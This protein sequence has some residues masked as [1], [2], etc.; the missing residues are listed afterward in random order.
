PEPANVAE[1]G[2]S[3]RPRMTC[4]TRTPALSTRREASPAR[5]SALE[6]RPM[7]RATRTARERSGFLRVVNRDRHRTRGND[8]GDGVLVHHLRHRVLEENHVLVER[9]D[10]PL[11]LDPVHEVDRDGDMLLAQSI[12]ERVLKQ[13]PFVAH[14]SAPFFSTGFPVYAGPFDAIIATTRKDTGPKGPV[15]DFARPMA[16]NCLYP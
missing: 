6:L 8:R 9:F 5:S 11:E 10:L 4:A 15:P 3:R 1:S 16:E 2:R 12:E 14:C 7:S 13:L